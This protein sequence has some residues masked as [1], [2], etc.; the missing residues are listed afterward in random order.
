MWEQERAELERGR[1]SAF[2]RVMQKDDV[3]GGA[4]RKSQEDMIESAK[5][6]RDWGTQGQ[7]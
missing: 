4:A 5:D 2:G 7:R 3:A 6:L 1:I